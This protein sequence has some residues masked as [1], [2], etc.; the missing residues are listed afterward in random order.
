MITIRFICSK[1]K[2]RDVFVNEVLMAYNR[3]TS[4][5]EID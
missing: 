3:V 1:N 4:E 2:I 5:A